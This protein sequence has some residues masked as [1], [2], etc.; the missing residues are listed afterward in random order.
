MIHSIS[1]AKTVFE[2]AFDEITGGSGLPMN[3]PKR[4]TLA[5][6][7]ICQSHKQ[8]LKVVLIEILDQMS[9]V[10]IPSPS[11]ISPLD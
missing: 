2:N 5:K 1:Q 7:K 10:G 3:T 9:H 6:M 4:E 8:L 11:D